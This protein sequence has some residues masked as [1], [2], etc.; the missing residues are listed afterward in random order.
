MSKSAS[1]TI[2]LPEPPSSWDELSDE[3]MRFVFKLQ[4]K[5]NVS[6]AEY[7]LK[8]FLHLMG[9]KVLT[10]AEKKDDGSFVYH[11]CRKGIRPLLRREDLNME[12]WEV[13][14]WIKTYLSFLDS[15]N[16]LTKLPFDSYKRWGK[17]F[18]APSMLML[19]VTYE[20]YSNAQN[21]LTAY[22]Q[23]TRLAESMLNNGSSIKAVRRV[24]QDVINARAGFLSHMLTSPQWQLTESDSHSTRLHVH[25]AYKYSSQRAEQNKRYFKTAPDYLFWVMVQFFQGCL[26]HFREELPDLFK[27]SDENGNKTAWLI[28]VDTVNAVQKYQGYAMQQDVYDSEAVFIFGVLNNMVQE[29]KEV[30]KIRKKNH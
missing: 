18:K 28:E 10:R 8:V 30:E 6:V 4:Q 9:L 14:Y 19:D 15:P 23:Y 20:Q 29:A 22:S 2:D 12:A 5:K 3:Q 21:Y 1:K 7:K 26:A 25:R 16:T 11:F 24:Q 27:E 17:R 13:D